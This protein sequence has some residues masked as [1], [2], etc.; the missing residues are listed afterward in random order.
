LTKAFLAILTV[1]AAIIT[2]LQFLHIDFKALD[3]IK[4][5]IWGIP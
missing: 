5:L 3:F 4:S 2:M 1:V